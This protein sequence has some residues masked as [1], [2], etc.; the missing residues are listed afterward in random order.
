MLLSLSWGNDAM[1]KPA[2]CSYQFT[3]EAIYEGIRNFDKKAEEAIL[4]L[5]LPWERFKYHFNK[6][7]RRDFYSCYFMGDEL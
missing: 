3:K 5:T 2:L 7:E 4:L 6:E 1:A